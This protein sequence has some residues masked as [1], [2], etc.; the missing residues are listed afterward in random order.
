MLK[1]FFKEGAIV[2]FFQQVSK[3]ISSGGNSGEILFYQRET[4]RKTFFTT[5]VIGKYQISTSDSHD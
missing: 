3:N 4:K 1:R 2:K 5:T